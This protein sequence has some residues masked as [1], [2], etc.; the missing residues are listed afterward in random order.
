MTGGLLQLKAYGSENIYLNAN[1]QISFFRSIYRRHTNFSMENFD[2]NYVGT[3]NMTEDT[4]TTYTFNI[5]RNADLLGPIFL[6][7]GLPTVYSTSDEQFQWIKNIGAN[8]INYASLFIAGQHICRIEGE[9]INNYYRLQKDYSTNLN[10]NELIGHNKTFY[11]PTMLDPVSNQITYRFSNVNP[12][13]I[14]VNLY[15]PIP[16]YFSGNSGLYLPLIALQKAEVQIVVEL[17][18]ISELYTIVETR[19]TN[20]LYNKRIKPNSLINTQ[21]IYNFI[22]QKTL[23]QAFPV[24]MD[25]QYIFLDNDERTQFADLPHEYL[26]EQVQYKKFFGITAHNILDI[27]FFH[28]TK[29]I[30]FYLRKTD[31]GTIFNQWSNYGN[32]DYYGEKFLEGLLNSAEYRTEMSLNNIR[33]QMSENISM[34]SINILTTAKFLMNGQDRTNQLSHRYWNIVQPFQYHL[35]S[36]V[37]PFEENDNFYTFSFSLEPDNFQPSGSCNLTNLKSFQL[38]IDTV[39]PPLNN[40]LFLASYIIKLS[41]PLFNNSWRNPY[42]SN[43]NSINNVYSCLFEFFSLQTTSINTGIVYGSYIIPSGQKFNVKIEPVKYVLNPNGTI[44]NNTILNGTNCNMYFYNTNDIYYENHLI[45][46]TKSVSELQLVFVYREQPINN[47]ITLQFININVSVNTFDTYISNITKEMYDN[48]TTPLINY[49]KIPYNIVYKTI[50]TILTEQISQILKDNNRNTSSTF[51]LVSVDFVNFKIYGKMNIIQTIT[52]NISGNIQETIT[53]NRYNTIF[54]FANVYKS[55]DTYVIPLTG[56]L[57]NVY[58]E[59]DLNF[60]E[61]VSQFPKQ[62]LPYSIIIFNITE[63]NNNN[64]DNLKN[65]LWNYDLFV[66]AHSYNLLRIADGTG[67]VAY[68]T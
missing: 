33:Q 43:I 54:S 25:V 56:F 10:Y 49:T 51:S 27:P 21:S 4:N 16:F 66:E 1:P 30:R 59:T 52:T 42:Y 68:S 40:Y 5:K 47:Q 8:I 67:A 44:Q 61:Q 57:L 6:V 3:P 60:N 62:F 15:I 64:P 32:N 38:E 65:Y 20:L 45:E 50:D 35:G 48:L 55:G 19:K 13:I 22:K 31:N 46:G 26:I 23:K 12:S 2:L 11:N 28:P 9:T 63:F 58:L 7:V 24:N 29:E 39:Y 37:Y 36:T 34:T 53:T 17:K 14:G 41:N 18:K